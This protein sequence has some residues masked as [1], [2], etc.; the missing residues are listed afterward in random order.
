[1]KK[2]L[3]ALA[4]ITALAA[5]AEALI[6]I[7]IPEDPWK[8][9]AL[10]EAFA[11]TVGAFVALTYSALVRQLRKWAVESPGRAFGVPFLMLIPYL[12]LALGTRT[13]SWLALEKLTTYIAVPVLL[14]M[15]DRQRKAEKVGWRDLAAM[16]ALGLPVSANWLREVW[17]WPQ[18]LY[19]FRPLFCVCVGGYAF[20]VIRNLE[21]VGYRLLWRKGDFIDG[22]T[23]FAAFTLLGIPLGLALNF[24]H[25]H[26]QSISPG[27]IALQFIGVYLT[28]AIPEE[29]LF[30]G[31]LQNFLVRSIPQGPRGL[32]GLILAS[33]VFGASHLHHAPVPN[34]RYAM[35][36]TLAGLF[37]GNA[38]RN[39]HRLSSSALTHALVDTAWHFWF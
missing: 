25:P 7:R 19:V 28:V 31:I 8:L 32:Y 39:R 4:A 9:G 6:L 2:T 16:L 3:L 24:L 23:N 12:V 37:Y 14:L 38:Y 21:G 18:D 35:L 10:L 11:L 26:W 22:L 36:A 20:M 34:W 13:F 17:V 33:V 5:L 15:P 1:M 27:Q 29:L 30:R